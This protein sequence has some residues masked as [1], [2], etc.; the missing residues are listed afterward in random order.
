MT[1]KE[2]T[3]G[4]YVSV[5]LA[6]PVYVHIEQQALKEHI[7]IATWIRHAVLAACPPDIRN[8][9][10]ETGR[11]RYRRVARKP[12]QDRPPA[13]GQEKAAAKPMAA[14]E[15]MAERSRDQVIALAAKGYRENA[16]SA[17]AHLPY[18]VVQQI[19]TTSEG[20]P[21]KRRKK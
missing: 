4:E 6:R 7:G 16:I 17:I 8:R 10:E 5:Y 20:Q 2:R 14:F 13:K 21:R 3:T 11:G 1:P 15:D 18:R 19:L 9:A 12:A